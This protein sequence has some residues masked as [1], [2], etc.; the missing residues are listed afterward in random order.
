MKLT[1]EDWPASLLLC[2]R[3]FGVGM[4][5]R[6]SGRSH[7]HTHTLLTDSGDQDPSHPVT[8]GKGNLRHSRKTTEVSIERRSV[9]HADVKWLASR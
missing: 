7:T 6:R 4:I 3:E 9:W 5:L 1:G 2:S 8:Q